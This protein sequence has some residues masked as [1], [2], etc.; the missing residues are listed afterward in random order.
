[1][2]RK[3]YTYSMKLTGVI[4]HLFFNVV[5]TVAVFLLAAMLGKNI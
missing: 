5:F 3:S 4:F 1:M 2:E